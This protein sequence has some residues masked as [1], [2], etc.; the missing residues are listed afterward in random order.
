VKRPSIDEAVAHR[1]A[2]QFVDAVHIQ[3]LHD[4]AAVGVEQVDGVGDLLAIRSRHGRQT[5]R[6]G[7]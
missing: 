2:H 6:P 4:A 1:E 7:N 5:D 3:L